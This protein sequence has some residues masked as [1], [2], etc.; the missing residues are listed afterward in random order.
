MRP[1]TLG[2]GTPDCDHPKDW[3]E[4]EYATL[5]TQ[6]RTALERGQLPPWLSFSGPDW[7]TVSILIDGRP[8]S[9]PLAWPNALLIASWLT[10][11]RNPH[12]LP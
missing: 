12:A 1:F 2:T 8:I 9:F 5:V 6:T 10:E 11:A 4:A 7:Y 3:R